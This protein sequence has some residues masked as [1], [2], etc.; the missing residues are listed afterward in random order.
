MGRETR[1]LFFGTAP[2][3]KNEGTVSLRQKSRSLR[4][5]NAFLAKPKRGSPMGCQTN[6]QSLNAICEGLEMYNYRQI[7]ISKVQKQLKKK[8]KQ[9]K[10]AGA[11]ERSIER[12]QLNGA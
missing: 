10:R 4:F 1:N 9:F 7:C 5:E 8:Q 2:G 6:T 12:M 3:K 11:V